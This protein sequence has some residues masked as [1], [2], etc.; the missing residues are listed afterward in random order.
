VRYLSIEDVLRVHLA[1]LAASGGIDG[2]RDRRGLETAVMQP[3]SGFA[4]DLFY[5]T[6][7]TCAAAYLHF[8]SRN[9][10]FLDGNKRTAWIAALLFLDR[11][12]YV[13]REHA[14]VVEPFVVS[15]AV[16]DA[17]IE[18]AADWFACRMKPKRRRGR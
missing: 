5:P 2:V 18:R 8:I 3:Q 17:N 11:N 12:G 14:D 9:H 6:L 15:V 4:D 7:S 1:V 10:A 16:G 13:V